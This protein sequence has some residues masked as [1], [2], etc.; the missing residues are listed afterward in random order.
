MSTVD[1]SLNCSDDNISKSPGVHKWSPRE[2]RLYGEAQRLYIELTL[3]YESFVVFTA[4]LMNKVARIAQLLI[5]RNK[6]PSHNCFTDHKKYFLKA[7]NIPYSPKEDYARLI[8]EETDWFDNFLKPSRDK[9]ILHS[10]LYWSGTRQSSEGGVRFVKADILSGSGFREQAETMTSLKWK[11][12]EIY[13]QLQE[14]P[15]NLWE[16]VEFFMSNNVKFEAKDKEAF[17]SVLQ[18]C[19][20]TL[21]SLHYL[22]SCVQNF[23]KEFSKVFNGSYSDQ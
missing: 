5:G 22:A 20:S 15:D 16:L 23:L 1:S 7:E 8:R 3:D 4:V 6:I 12:L 9:I 11:Y 2:R 21:P 18:G 19:G 17:Y 14:V 10:D 13:P